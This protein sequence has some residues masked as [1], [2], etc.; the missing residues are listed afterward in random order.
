[1]KSTHI[2]LS[3]L[4]TL[5]VLSACHNHDIAVDEFKITRDIVTT[6]SSSIHFEGTFSFTGNV[7]DIK[8]LLGQDELL[9][10]P[11]VHNM[12][13]KGFDFEGTV[14]GLQPSSNYY[15]RYSFDWGSSSNFVTEIKMAVTEDETPV[16][17]LVS[18]DSVTNC[19]Q[20]SA[21]C[22]GTVIKR[23]SHPI[24]ERG[25]CYSTNNLP[26]VDDNT[27][28]DESGQNAETFS[29]LLNNLNKNTTYYVR[30]YAYYD[31]QPI[32]SPYSLSF[33]TVDPP[34]VITKTPNSPSVGQ[35][36]A[37]GKITDYNSS[38]Q[39]LPHGIC[40]SKTDT[41]PSLEA[42]D[43]EVAVGSKIQSDGSFY[44]MIYNLSPQTV[45]YIRAF[46]GNSWNVGYGEVKTVTTR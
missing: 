10:D 32:Y 8:L 24:T 21:L 43:T 4:I 18:I 46:A 13:M 12:T 22:H 27:V 26:T 31:N 7:D 23:D 20:T 38:Y 14:Q 19:A 40:Y 33:K 5:F 42:P 44:V 41:I 35:I 15:Y 16:P 17:P 29:L 11:T 3:L 36:V 37:W 28:R 39:D 2:T 6:T 9:K 45:Y 34:T 25:F 1:M 30:T